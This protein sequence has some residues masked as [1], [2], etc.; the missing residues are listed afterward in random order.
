MIARR[1]L[2]VGAMAL[3]ASALAGATVRSVNSVGASPV[4]SMRSTFPIR[5]WPRYSA[6]I[7]TLSVP[8]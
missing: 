8:T 7:W 5:S 4:F 6:I 1:D 3:A 2:L